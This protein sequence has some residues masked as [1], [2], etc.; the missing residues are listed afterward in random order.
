MLRAAG[1]MRIEAAG[2]T[3]LAAAGG[4]P[5]WAVGRLA[6]ARFVNRGAGALWRTVT[7]RGTPIASPV[8]RPAA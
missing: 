7:V 3:P 5:R 4:A 2:A 6:D 1:V 8:P